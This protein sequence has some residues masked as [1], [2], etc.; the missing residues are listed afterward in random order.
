MVTM[1]SSRIA[2]TS[3]TP[4]RMNTSFW[5]LK[6]AR[7]NSALTHTALTL[8]SISSSTP[9][10]VAS[11]EIRWMSS[12]NSMMF[13]FRR[14]PSVNGSSAVSGSRSNLK[15]TT[16]SSFSQCRSWRA[17]FLRSP[18]AG[19]RSFQTA[20]I[21]FSFGTTSL[22]GS[23]RSA[24]V[25]TFHHVWH[26]SCHS[27]TGISMT[28]TSFHCSVIVV[29]SRRASHIPRFRLMSETASSR[30]GYRSSCCPKIPWN[31]VF[32]FM[33]S[34]R[35]VACSFSSCVTCSMGSRNS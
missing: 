16:L 35:S 9:S 5:S 26:C 2:W 18:H 3:S 23:S 17:G 4:E 22:R 21:C 30:V 33:R 6:F 7:P 12:R 29:T 14:D 34:S 13:F 10:C 31:S 25:A 19:T 28:S 11:V 8:P 15:P 1:L 27:L 20:A 32:F 24:R